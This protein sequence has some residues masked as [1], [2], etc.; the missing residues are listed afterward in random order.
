MRQ[1]MLDGRIGKDG[2]KVLKSNNGKD[3]I[4]FSLANDSFVNGENKTEWFEIS[5]FDPYIVENKSKFMTQGRYA[6]VQGVVNSEVTSKNGKIYLN[7]YVKAN[8]IELPSFGTKKEESNEAQT[9]IST[10]TGGTRSEQIVTGQPSAAPQPVQEIHAPVA[11]VQQT[12]PQPQVVPSQAVPAG[13]GNNTD[14]LP[15]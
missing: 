11:P 1:I 6:I 10:F 2:A 5:C 13:W 8:N 4:R 9:Q 12:T 3:Y 15:F 7:H 14:D